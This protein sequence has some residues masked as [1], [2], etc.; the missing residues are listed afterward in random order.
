MKSSSFHS[1][2]IYT[3]LATSTLYIHCEKLSNSHFSFTSKMVI[4]L[5]I[6]DN[7]WMRVTIKC[8]IFTTE[9]IQHFLPDSKQVA[10]S[11]SSYLVSISEGCS[12]HHS[13]I[14]K[15]LVV[16]VDS[17]HTLHSCK[18]QSGVKTV[19][20]WLETALRGGGN[21]ITVPRR[22]VTFVQVGFS[23]SWHCG[24]FQ[25]LHQQWEEVSSGMWDNSVSWPPIAFTL[26]STVLGWT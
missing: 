7:L 13:I 10:A 5:N 3:A 23:K 25:Y 18:S 22:G 21:P 9:A 26:N 14:T 8:S 17:R 2:Y 1:A 11:Q 24:R 12:H 6:E 4:N 15:L 19:L 20:L 16:V